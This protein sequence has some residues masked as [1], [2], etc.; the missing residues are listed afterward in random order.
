MR[1]A[2][3]AAGIEAEVTGRE[4][5][6]YGVYPPQDDRTEEN[7]SEVLI[8]LVSA[9]SSIPCPS[10][11]WRRWARCT[12]C[13]GPCPAVQGPSRHSTRSTATSPCTPRQ[14]PYGTPV[15]FQFRTRD[16]HHIAEEG[17]ASLALQGCRPDA[18]RVQKRT[19]QWAA[20]AA[21]HPEPDRRFGR[22]PRTRQG[23]P[24][25]DAVYV[26]TPRGKIISLPRGATPVD[27]AYAIHT[28][29][30]NQAVAAKVNGEFVPLRTELSSGDIGRNHHFA[31]L[32]PERAMAQLRAHRPRPF[33]KSAITFGPSNTR[34]PWPSAS[35]CSNRR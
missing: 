8:S 27:F 9:S 19:H 25:P 34:S 13:I 4:K 32:A 3:P 11:T 17:V 21:R 16:M 5:T 6:L 1:V 26:F 31:G 14:G 35:A 12:S 24:V 2:L 15:E 29:I 22:V 23:R 18:Q 30:G 28:D 7:V 20:V 33:R 10:A